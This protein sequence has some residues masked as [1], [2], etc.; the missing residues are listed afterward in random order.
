MRNMDKDL[1]KDI[2]AEFLGESFSETQVDDAYEY[3]EKVLSSL[4]EAHESFANVIGKPFKFKQ[5][6]VAV[7]IALVYFVNM[8]SPEG[9][10]SGYL[11]AF[12]LNFNRMWDSMIESCMDTE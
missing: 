6:E 7:T 12:Y 5:M 4:I 9:N 2:I 10:L 11:K 3:A 1:T 8:G